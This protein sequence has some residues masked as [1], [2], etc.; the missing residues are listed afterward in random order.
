MRHVRS[1]SW[2]CNYILLSLHSLHNYSRYIDVIF[3]LQVCNPGIYGNHQCWS[4]SKSSVRLHETMCTYLG[5]KSVVKM[6]VGSRGAFIKLENDSS[7]NIKIL[8]FLFILLI[9]W[10]SHKNTETTWSSNILCLHQISHHHLLP[11]GIV[12]TM[13]PAKLKE[14][15]KLVWHC[16]NSSKYI[17]MHTNINGNG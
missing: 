10:M 9:C 7:S 15:R 1:C 8:F 5:R 12:T 13:V 16:R 3:K 17:D 2:L 6:N 11:K 4:Y 14:K